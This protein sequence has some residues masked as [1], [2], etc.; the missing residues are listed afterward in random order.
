[1]KKQFGPWEYDS[2][3]MILEYTEYGYQIDLEEITTSAEMLDWIFQIWNKDWGKMAMPQLLTAFDYLFDPQANLCSW[4]K[5]KKI[6]PQKVIQGNL[7]RSSAA[8]AG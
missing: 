4:G 7:K 5:G 8:T 1:M 3:L 2:E 6:D